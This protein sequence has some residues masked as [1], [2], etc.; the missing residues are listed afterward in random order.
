MHWPTAHHKCTSTI[1]TTHTR[2]NAAA[3]EQLINNS[4]GVHVQRPL[5]PPAPA[6]VAPPPAAAGPT[7]QFTIRPMPARKTA[8]VK[9]PSAEVLSAPP[10]A[11]AAAAPVLAPPAAAAAAPKAK[12]LAASK[13]SSKQAAA[14]AAKLKKQQQLE[15]EADAAFDSDSTEAGSARDGGPKRRKRIRNAKQ[16]EL[17]RLAQQRYRCVGGWH[18]AVCPCARVRLAAAAAT[19]LAPGLQPRCHTASFAACLPTTDHHTNRERRKSKFST[20]Q[21]TVEDLS[22]RLSTLSTLEAANSELAGRNVQLEGVVKAQRETISRQAQQLQ[23]QAGQLSHQARQLQAQVQVIQQ[24]DRTI[25]ELRSRSLLAAGSAGAGSSNEAAGAGSSAG[26]ANAAAVPDAELLN[27]QI[28]LAMRAVL[29]GVSSMASVSL[30]ASKDASQM[31]MQAMVSQ[32]P[33][34]LLQQIHCCCREVAL[35]LKK[36]EMKDTPH[37]ISVPCC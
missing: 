26:Q 7:Q 36:G 9:L 34:A 12:Q 24:R 15:E 33:D 30:A 21:E 32:L 5:A 16:Q 18:L 20:L 28:A 2:S 6:V 37:A 22:S 25:S 31:Q 4:N 8:A 3:P 29:T 14:A 17:N 11:A 35:H 19:M 27:E 23:T 1:H 10:P 13:P